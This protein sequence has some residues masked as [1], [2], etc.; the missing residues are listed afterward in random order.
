[1]SGRAGNFSAAAAWVW[2][3][4][5]LA[6]A[7]RKPLPTPPPQ[8]K[9]IPRRASS[10]APTA[11]KLDLS[12]LY[13]APPGFATRRNGG[14]EKSCLGPLQPLTGFPNQ[15]RRRPIGGALPRTAPSRVVQ[16]H[17]ASSGG[18]AMLNYDFSPFYRSTV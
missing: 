1:M 18:Y 11:E 7:W 6:A 16:G 2:A 8:A 4:P 12:R 13:A 15:H 17:V 3:H 14:A 9:Q 5:R 10:P